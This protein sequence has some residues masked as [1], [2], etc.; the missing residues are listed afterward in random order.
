MESFLILLRFWWAFHTLL[1]TIQLW[2]VKSP[3]NFPRLCVFLMYTFYYVNISNLTPV[4]G[5]LSDLMLFENCHIS[6]YVWNVII[7]STFYKLCVKA[8]L[9]GWKLNLYNYLWLCQSSFW[10]CFLSKL[11]Y[12]HQ[13]FIDCMFN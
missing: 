11:L 4:Y 12:F 3:Q 8:E 9:Y 10:D 5:R 6:L 2:I 7:S 1:S 13:I